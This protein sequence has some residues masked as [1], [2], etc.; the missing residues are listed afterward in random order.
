MPRSID[1]VALPTSKMR[2]GLMVSA[3]ERVVEEGGVVVV[4]SEL[5]ESAGPAVRY[6]AATESPTA[7]MR[8]I[9]R[10]RPIDALA[11]AELVEAV[12]HTRIYLLS[13]QS[14]V[15]VEDLGLTPIDGAEQLQRLIAQQPSCILLSNAQFAIATAEGEEDPI[16]VAPVDRPRA[17]R[18]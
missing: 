10:E 11:A 9:V 12:S 7:A 16:D 8:E 5:K 6:L 4:C 1:P 15:V 14:P 17:K 3:A 13:G 2:A 18:K